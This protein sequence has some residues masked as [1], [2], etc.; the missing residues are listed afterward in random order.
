MNSE[1]DKLLKVV[2]KKFDTAIGNEETM[3]IKRIPID[4]PQMSYLFGGGIPIGRIHRFRGP[5]SGGKSTISIY[6]ASQIQ[7]KLPGFL[8]KPGK[9]VVVYID[10]ERTFDEK[11]AT[12]LGLNCSNDKL[13]HLLPDD[14]ETATDIV[15][16][17]IKTDSLA[18]I[19]LDSDAASPSRAQMTDQFGKASFG[20]SARAL[21]EMIR[22]LNI[23]CANYNTTI[24]WISQE[25]V[26]M[27]FGAH[28]P[29]VSG[30][31]SVSYYSST[32]NRVTKIDVIK[33][34]NETIG[35]QIRIRNYK[36]KTSIAWR[37]AEV[38]LFFNG[39]FN[40]KDEYLDFIIK[41]EIFKQGGAWFTNEEYGVKLNGRVK[42]QEWLNENPEVFEKMKL[43]VDA[44]LTQETSLDINNVDPE[45]IK[46]DSDVEI[47]EDMLKDEGDS[48]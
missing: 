48:K 7:K 4:S 14:I 8:N 44:L 39:G 11:F 43:Q 36:N 41:F 27:S 5:A 2:K 22:K 25:R 6:L 12:N 32:V 21:S 29:A 38:N 3:R 24:F 28:L 37:D 30:G 46:E 31:E 45:T 23:I 26:N 9:D 40:S 35:Q 34:A 33:N 16:D 15:S 1:L 47:T 10:F 17:L 18:A 42:V 19:I 13:I 20:G